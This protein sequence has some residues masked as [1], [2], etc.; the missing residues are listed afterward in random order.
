MA[1]M[2]CM[3]TL[4]GLPAGEKKTGFLPSGHSE[5]LHSNE[6][7]TESSVPKEKFSP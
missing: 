3:K 5:L 7:S 2:E 6:M 1:V 4:T